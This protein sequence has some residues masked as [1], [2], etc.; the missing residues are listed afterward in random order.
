MLRSQSVTLRES[1]MTIPPNITS[2]IKKW[3][4]DNMYKTSYLMQH[5]ANVFYLI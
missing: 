2:N 5:K 1:K 4:D 3:E